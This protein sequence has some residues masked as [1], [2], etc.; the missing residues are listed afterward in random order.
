MQGTKAGMLQWA[1]RTLTRFWHRHRVRIETHSLQPHRGGR[2]T[3]HKADTQHPALGHTREHSTARQTPQPAH[4]APGHQSLQTGTHT[5]IQPTPTPQAAFPLKVCGGRPETGFVC[6]PGSQRPKLLVQI[7]TQKPTASQ[8]QRASSI[9]LR[10]DRVSAQPPEALPGRFFPFQHPYNIQHTPT[11][12][13]IG[14]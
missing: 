5:H 14:Q 4:A 2:C 11:P 10:K 7:K 8:A 6:P 13:S 9:G 12:H 1:S 3:S